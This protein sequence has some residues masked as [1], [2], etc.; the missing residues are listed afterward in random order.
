MKPVI[1]YFHGF[2]SSAESSKVA[3]LR[4]YYDEKNIKF[5]CESY[6]TFD[7]LKAHFE[8][9]ALIEDNLKPSSGDVPIFVGTSLGA[10]WAYY[11][12]ETY[13]GY[14][15]VGNPSM[16]PRDSLDK[17]VKPS[18]VYENFAG[19]EFSFTKKMIDNYSSFEVLDKFDNAPR[20]GIALFNTG[21]EI[22]GP[23]FPKIR[24]ALNE[25]GTGCCVDLKGGEH[26]FSN[27]EALTE[28]INDIIAFQIELGIDESW[29]E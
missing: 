3:H 7:P 16:F 14:Y 1:F 2:A 11:F 17:Y 6:N 21:D 25:K 28:G 29:A 20:G 4:K 22:L 15:V 23:I 9:S 8:I 24:R 13:D 26:R 19:E 10:F 18:G 5:V 12:A 27:V